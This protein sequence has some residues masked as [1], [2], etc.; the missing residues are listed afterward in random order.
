[1]SSGAEISNEVMER[2][3]MGVIRICAEASEEVHCIGHIRTR[4]ESNVVEG[5]N[6][7]LVGS[8]IY[9]RFGRSDGVGIGEW[10]VSVD[11]GIL[12]LSVMF[13]K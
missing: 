6:I 1:M 13:V 10:R 7:R 9:W 11:V 3:P 4:A 8:G 5:T 12:E 2:L